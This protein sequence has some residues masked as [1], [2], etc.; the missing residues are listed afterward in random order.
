MRT[1][2]AGPATTGIISTFFA[3]IGDMDALTAIVDPDAQFVG[4]RAGTYSG[5]PLYGTFVGYDGL[6]RF[7][8]GLRDAFQPQ[9]FVIDH[10]LESEALGFASGRFE[11]RLRSNGKLHRSHWAVRCQ[12]T[13]G[14]ISRYRFY[15]DTAALEAAFGIHTTSREDVTTPDP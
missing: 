7:V 1:A 14:R 10:E 4:V 9:L 11:H 13:G 2:A 8:A 15:E 5:L 3:N 12:F 6:E